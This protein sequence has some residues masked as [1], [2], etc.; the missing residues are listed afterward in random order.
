MS[1]PV[2]PCKY[3]DALSHDGPVDVRRDGVLIARCADG[4]AAFCWLQRETHQSV[5]WACRHEGWSVHV[6]DVTPPDP[7]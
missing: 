2:P 3:P 1:R 7:A 5:D 6:A 4:N